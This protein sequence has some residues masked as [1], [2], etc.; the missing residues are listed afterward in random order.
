[1]TDSDS[2]PMLSPGFWLHHAALTWRAALDAGLRPLGLTPTQFM[3]LASAG[4]LEHVAGPPT[5]Q[6]VAEQAGADRMMTSKIVRALQERALLERRTDPTDARAV[7]LS[8]TPAGRALVRQATESR[9][10]SGYQVFRPPRDKNADD[11]A[12]D[13]GNQIRIV[14][15]TR[16]ASG[17][18]RRRGRPSGRS[19]APAM[20]PHPRPPTGRQHQ[21]NR[22]SAADQRPS[23]R[24]PA[25]SRRAAARPR[26]PR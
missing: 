25:G 1:M 23:G 24:R 6:A 22:R 18:P 7:R 17:C 21:G 16:V 14:T 19:P 11:V 20:A 9:P 10:H 13:R 4:W 15:L 2:G 26:W 5:Q 8:L 12:Y 3:L